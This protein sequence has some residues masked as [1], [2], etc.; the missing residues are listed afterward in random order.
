LQPLEHGGRKIG[1][2]WD[3]TEKIEKAKKNVTIKYKNLPT[4]GVSLKLETIVDVP[5]FNLLALNYEAEGF[6]RWTPFCKESKLVKR[7]SR[8]SNAMW[9]KWDL[10]P[11]VSAREGYL[12]GSGFDRL[13]INGSIL[14]IAKTIH[15]DPKLA[16]RHG[17]DVPTKS[18]YVRMEI[19]YIGTD[20]V[21]IS[22]TQTKMRLV[23]TFD[24]QIKFVP[25][26][27][28]SWIARKGSIYLLETMVKHAASLEG[29]TWN[30][31]FERSK[32]FYGWLKDLLE[33]HATD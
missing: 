30:A 1:K 25:L 4:G 7:L 27:L 24:P 23:C 31:Y 19:P 29:D 9:L 32:D 14:M 13:D 2:W 22:K 26:S 33:K 10:P 18:K 28:S 17:L 20:L 16:L 12:I 3:Q 15:N 11:P 5:L 21:P 6:V 8:A